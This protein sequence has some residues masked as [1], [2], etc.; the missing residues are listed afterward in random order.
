VRWWCRDIS[1][2]C[3]MLPVWFSSRWCTRNASWSDGALRPVSGSRNQSGSALSG[4][5]IPSTVQVPSSTRSAAAT[6]AA[7]VSAG[8]SARAFGGSADSKVLTGK[9]PAGS[10]EA[11]P[12]WTCRRAQLRRRAS[13]L[14]RKD[15]SAVDM[16]RS[17]RTYHPRAGPFTRSP[18]VVWPALCRRRRSR[19]WKPAAPLSIGLACVDNR[20]DPPDAATPCGADAADGEPEVGTDLLVGEWRILGQQFDQ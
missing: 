2:T 13:S 18:A 7:T 16:R 11:S 6:T 14:T 19:A 3:L 20:P 17:R 10:G 4:R 15:T 5:P 1:Q 9:T 12:G 8:T